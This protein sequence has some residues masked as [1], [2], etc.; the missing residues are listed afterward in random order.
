MLNF[1][2]SAPLDVQ[3]VGPVVN[4]EKDYAIAKDL[5]GRIGGVT[6]AVDVHLAQVLNQPELRMKVDRTEA[7]QQGLSQRDVANDTLISLELERSDCSDPLVGH[8]QGRSGTPSRYRLPN[9]EWTRSTRC[10]KRRCSYRVAV[11][12]RHS[13]TWLRFGAI[14]PPSTSPTRMSCRRST[15][16]PTCRASIWGPCPTRSTASSCRARE[17]LPRGTSLVVRGQVQSMNA[18]F[19][20]LSYGILAAVVLVY[21]LMV[22]NFQ[23]WLDP[24]IILMALPRCSGGHRLDASSR[25]GLRFRCRR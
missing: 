21:L 1:G 8:G 23:S 2:L 6:G 18:S 24:M 19:R 17:S 15:C 20:G 25:R 14:G 9:T 13:G 11:R 5:E 22:V 10:A 4:N 3:V 16:R 12:P 7:S